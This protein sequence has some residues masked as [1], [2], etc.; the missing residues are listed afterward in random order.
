M[1]FTLTE[2]LV[3]IAIMGLLA[4][5]LLPALSQAKARA[6]RIRC[7]NNLRQLGFALQQFAADYHIYP[8]EVESTWLKQLETEGLGVAELRRGFM[9][10]GVW[11][12]PAAR[13]SDF[14]PSHRCS[15]YNPDAAFMW[16]QDKKV[17]D[18]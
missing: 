5:L 17:T 1:A 6:Q 4:A 13:W 12:C 10:R 15:P 2:L 3:V 14:P 7:V 8:S 9:E 11:R 16:V 18:F